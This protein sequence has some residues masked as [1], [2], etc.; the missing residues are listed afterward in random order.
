LVTVY[1]VT[2]R[3]PLAKGAKLKD[4]IMIVIN[5]WQMVSNE[6]KHYQLPQFKG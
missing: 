1:S 2:P 4:E 5:F 3:F 6:K